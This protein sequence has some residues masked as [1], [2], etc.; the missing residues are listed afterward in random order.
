MSQKMGW[1]RCGDTN[2]VRHVMRYL[3][4]DDSV[5]IVN[6]GDWALPLKEIRITSGFG[7][8]V[9]PK[10]SRETSKGRYR[11]VRIE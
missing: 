4:Q 5:P 11:N 10:L 7:G 3:E 6:N 2:Y 1:S 9:D 8:R